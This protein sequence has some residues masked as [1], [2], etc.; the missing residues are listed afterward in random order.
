MKNV[1]MRAFCVLFS[2][3]L[4]VAAN[5]LP[6]GAFPG[7]VQIDQAGNVYVAGVLNDHTFVAKLSPDASQ[8]VYMTTIAG[9]KADRAAALALGADG[10]AYITGFTT[11]PDFPATAGSLQPTAGNPQQAFAAKLD[12]QGK[13]QYATYI[14]GS[15]FT[16]G[17][18]IA[19]DASGSAYITGTISGGAAGFPVTPG[20]VSGYQGKPGAANNTAFIVKLDPAGSNA[21]ISMVGFGG[22]HIALDNAGNI[23]AV[24]A[25]TG[26]LTTTPG[27]FQENVPNTVCGTNFLLGSFPCS[28]QHVSRIDPTGARLIFATYV[29]GYYGA[30]P[31]GVGIDPDG[32][33]VLAGVTNSPDYPG[34]LRAYQPQ[35]LF[36]PSESFAPLANFSPPVDSGYVTKLD[37][38]GGALVWSTFFSGSGTQAT[39]NTYVDGDEITSM[40]LDPKG[41]VWIS[42]NAKSPDLPG[43]WN[44]P[45]V[46]RPAPPAM[47]GISMSTAGFITRLTSD[48]VKISPTQL[49]PVP[50][51]G[52]FNY[53]IALRGDGSAIEASYFT[54]V[55][56]SDPPRVASI[57][58]TDNTRLVRRAR[59]ASDFVGNETLSTAGFAA[60][61]RI[62][63]VVQR[64]HGDLQRNRRPHPVCVGRPGQSASPVRDFGTE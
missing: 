5:P 54:N 49:L 50:G 48:G 10:S 57:A 62:P 18:G 1:S 15:A 12:P 61:R 9:S 59:A 23:I 29:T 40:A 32:N 43:L 44:I 39:F 26:T 22:S 28:H 47:A 52:A 17:N 14:G 16:T 53:P 41:N 38:S 8:I 34:T 64:N 7:T 58:D 63:G 45:V 31:A 3:T 13:I 60:V 24:G 37:P 2:A 51:A 36:Y 55:N 11:S 4:A 20:S 25:V 19:V 56:L 21:L 6:D 27:A 42:G 35:Y 33:I 46:S 30:T